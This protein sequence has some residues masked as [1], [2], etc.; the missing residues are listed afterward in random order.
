M[1][2][3]GSNSKQRVDSYSFLIDGVTIESLV[4]KFP[5]CKGDRKVTTECQGEN[6]NHTAAV[7]ENLFR[8]H[9][10]VKL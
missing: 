7:S 10:I 3:F 4:H 2:L 6:I 8:E 5:Y 9:K 1:F